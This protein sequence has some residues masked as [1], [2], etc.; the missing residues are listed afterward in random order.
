MF[1]NVRFHL[2]AD[3]GVVMG[4]EHESP[5]AVGVPSG[6]DVAECLLPDHRVLGEL[7]NLSCPPEVTEVGDYVFPYLGEPRRVHQS[8]GQKWGQDWLK[9]CPRANILL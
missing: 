3:L 4:G 2:R 8:G 7:V 9:L 6:D 5:G 1:L